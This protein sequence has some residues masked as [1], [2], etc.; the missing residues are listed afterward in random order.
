[1]DE[2][3][4]VKL[5]DTILLEDGSIS[6]LYEKELGVVRKWGKHENV[7]KA[8]AYYIK[9]RCEDID[10]VQ[11][12]IIVEKLSDLYII[13]ATLYTHGFLKYLIEQYDALE[14]IWDNENQYYKY[15]LNNE[16]IQNFY[17]N[18]E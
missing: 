2:I 12:M 13:N 15:E 8:H 1:M 10:M 17:R 9:E 5:I 14:T 4:V 11:D 3:D 18:Y 16:A 6:V 7:K